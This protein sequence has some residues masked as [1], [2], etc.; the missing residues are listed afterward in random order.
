MDLGESNI[1]TIQ[2]DP[3]NEYNQQLC[4][5][6]PKKFSYQMHFNYQKNNED[7]TPETTGTRLLPTLLS[8]SAS[9]RAWR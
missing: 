3:S 9:T 8:V 2:S 5:K 6:R 4:E 1:T 7:G